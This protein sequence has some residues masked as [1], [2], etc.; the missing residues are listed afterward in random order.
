MLVVF[1][2]ILNSR[3]GNDCTAAPELI[4]RLPASEYTIADKGYDS[5]KLRELIRQK[6]SIPMVPRKSNSTIENA[7]MD[8]CLYK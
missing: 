3:G 2:L 7:D 5:E 6:S 8:W 4:E 1:P